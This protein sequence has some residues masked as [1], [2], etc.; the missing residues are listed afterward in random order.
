MAQGMCYA[1]CDQFSGSGMI[2]GVE[3]D[4]NAYTACIDD[5]DNGSGAAQV[6]AQVAV[7]IAA[8]AAALF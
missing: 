1:G 7:V 6:Y 5:C 8:A 2:D 4:G 3:A